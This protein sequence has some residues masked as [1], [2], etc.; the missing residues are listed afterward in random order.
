[1]PA[2]VVP[3]TVC[4]M[5]GKLAT[6]GCRGAVVFDRDGFPTDRSMAY[7]EYFVRGTEPTSYCP[8]HT[9]IYG[10][11]VATSGVASA[12]PPVAATSGTVG[13]PAL[14]PVD[15]LREATPSQAA[16]RADNNATSSADAPAG[17]SEPAPRK[18]GFWGR[19]F[20]R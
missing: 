12:T 3:V 8:L 4:R 9:G 19:L 14:T 18:R 20:R 17:T 10:A 11:A 7:T 15:H 6:D 2:T 16:G 1:M 13:S 5:S